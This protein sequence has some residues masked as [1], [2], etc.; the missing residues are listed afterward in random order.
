MVD[1]IG[2]CGGGAVYTGRGPVCGVIIRRC[3]TIGCPGVGL[4]GAAGVGGALTAA[5]GCGGG[6]AGAFGCAGGATT[7]VAAGVGGCTG[8]VTITA[9][10][11]AGFSA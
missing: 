6:V 4:G 10:G 8:G 9:G 5:G 7:T 1:A 3:G 11:A 2:L